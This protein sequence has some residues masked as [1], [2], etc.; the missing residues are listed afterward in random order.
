MQKR[1]LNLVE[2]EKLSI[3]HPHTTKIRTSSAEFT[4][5]FIHAQ[6]FAFHS[7]HVHKHSHTLTLTKYTNTTN[8]ITNRELVKKRK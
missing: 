5:I 2:V 6:S 3:G 8:T 7:L 1:G 4:C